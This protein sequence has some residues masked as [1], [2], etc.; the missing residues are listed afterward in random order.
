MRVRKKKCKAG[1]RTGKQ[2]TAAA[3]FPVSQRE[4]LKNPAGNMA[5]ASAQPCGVS[6]DRLC[7]KPAL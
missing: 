2:Y 3:S 7:G 4:K 5:G 6:M 1:A